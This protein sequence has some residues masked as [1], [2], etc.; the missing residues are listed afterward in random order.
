MKTHY[1][2]VYEILTPLMATGKISTTDAAK[3]LAKVQL[4]ET[5]L[6]VLE[7]TSFEL[8]AASKREDLAQEAEYEMICEN[9]KINGE[10]EE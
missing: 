4:L 10:G 8:Y 6:N 9:V 1:G 7:K 3:I 5:R 2:E